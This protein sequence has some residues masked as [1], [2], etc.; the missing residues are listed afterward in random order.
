MGQFAYFPHTE[1]EVK[2]MLERI[3][4]S[5]LDALYADVPGEYL[6]KGEYDLPE[7]LS[8]GEV[9]SFFDSLGKKNVP[10]KV[11]V[12]GGCYDHY[13]PAVIPALLSRSEFL[14]AYT[15]YQPEISQG[16]LR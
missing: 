14:T 9:R 11:F 13:S 2:S 6:R 15:P 4:V 12:G 3:G 8:E 5:D 16:T 1:G 10:L 7:A